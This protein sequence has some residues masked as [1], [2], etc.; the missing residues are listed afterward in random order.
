M[1]VD[2]LDGLIRLSEAQ[3]GLAVLR[4]AGGFGNLKEMS[5]FSV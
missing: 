5:N 2:F 3:S 1:V 4:F